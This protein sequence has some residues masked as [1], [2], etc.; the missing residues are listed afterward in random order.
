MPTELIVHAVHQGGMRI[1]ASAGDHEVQ[2]DYP[3]TTGP[4]TGF[5]PLQL[6][7]ASLAGCAGN[8]LALLLQRMNQPVQ[9]IEVTVR[10]SRRDEHPTV[11]TS[12]TQ[13]FVVR[14]SGVDP[15]AVTRALEQAEKHLCPVWAMLRPGTP[16]RASVRVESG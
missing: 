3:L 9:G 13:D 16:I 4:L 11:L 14:G 12:I 2:M 1:R 15:E 7:L 10:A 6:L 8:T 5:T